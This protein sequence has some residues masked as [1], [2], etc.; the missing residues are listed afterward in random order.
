MIVAHNLLA[1][2]A[3]RMLGLNGKPIAKSTEKLS[4]GY[5]INR[6]ADDAAG[7]AISEKMRRQIRGLRQGAI[8]TTDGISWVKIG[9]GAMNEVSDMLNRMTELA[10]KAANGTMSESDRAAT[11]SEIR[12]LKKEIDRVATTT[13]FNEF[14]IFDN[15]NYQTKMSIAGGGALF[16]AS[17]DETTGEFSFGGVII[18]GKRISWNDIDP[19]MVTVDGNGDQVF[20]PGDYTYSRDGVNLTV[21]WKEGAEGPDLTMEFAVGA[22]GGGIRF[23]GNTF[24]WEDLVDEDGNPASED[25]VHGGN[26]SLNCGDSVVSFSIPQDIDT[27]GELINAINACAGQ[28]ITQ[29]LQSE[30]I[31]SA[32]E[33][34]VTASFVKNIWISNEVAAALTNAQNF[35]IFV[36]AD[37]SGIWLESADGTKM[38]DSKMTWAEMGIN[39]W[40]SGADI[41]ASK[42]YRYECYTASNKDT[43]YLS[44][45]FNLSEVTSLD[46]VIDGLDRMELKSVNITTNYGATIKADTSS[47]GGNPNIKGFSSSAHNI[48]VSFAEEIDL[49]RD[50]NNKTG[51]VTKDT[52]IEVQNQNNVDTAILKFSGNNGD[53]TYAGDVSGVEADMALDV[54][55]YLDYIKMWAIEA[56]LAGTDLDNYVIP[57]LTDLVGPGNITT[58][59]HFTD[60]VT[61]TKDMLYTPGNSTAQLQPDTTYPAAFI[62]FSAVTDLDTLL[63]KGFDSTCMTCNNHY[64]VVF[65]GSLSGNAEYNYKAEGQNHTL[66]VSIDALK[67]RVDA[68]ETIAEGLVHIMS[69]VFDFHYTQYAAGAPNGSPRDNNTLY[70]LDYRP[71][72][73]GSN[74][75]E[76]GTEPYNPTSQGIY[77]VSLNSAGNGSMQLKYAYDF[78]EASK[79]LEVEMQPDPNGE[80]I[81]NG[82]GTYSK[83][84]PATY[85]GERR[86]N[87]VIVYKD[88]DGNEVTRSV[89]A[90]SYAKTAVEDMLSSTTVSLDAKD[91]TYMR[92]SGKENANVAVRGLFQNTS[93]IGSYV[94]EGIRIQHSA[95]TDDFTIIPRFALNCMAL[96][97]S[98]TSTKTMDQA[99]DT[100][101]SLAHASNYVFSKRALYG[102]CQNRLEHT[103]NNLLN[104][105]ENTEAADSRIRD[106][107]MAEEMVDYSLHN[108]LQQTAQAMLAQAN[109]S[110][111]GVMSLL[112]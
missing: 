20:R 42:T 39:S 49:G 73:I 91:Y 65:K 79:C 76:F 94:E 12:Q 104:T 82:N 26:W 64:S 68:G 13:K 87:A 98:H 44:F 66:E 37:E 81:D 74:G 70:I 105:V 111:Q 30:Y 6:A 28:K 55:S 90:A 59:G 83:Y 45:D 107:D 7:L 21:S 53:I 16:D 1:M 93:G 106:T 71:N 60:T 29:N 40:D 112:S 52:S 102:A 2:N 11:D 85:N 72:T 84:D 92:L 34:A 19:S 25:N 88:A 99:L 48:K 5:K 96:G 36:R 50:F 97:L 22:D 54:E 43:P 17:Y 46:S 109:Q 77:N 56:A 61:I 38:A 86:V 80:Y 23:A 100:L 103:Y 108:I 57:T 89:A 32:N 9:D 35:S 14:P 10:V 3:N 62:D 31:G 47:Q 101:D 8:N 63:L 27:F 18:G 41:S 24:D 58:S 15:A 4:S 78:S 33:K 95:E 75:A 51:A 110:G 69:N 67:K